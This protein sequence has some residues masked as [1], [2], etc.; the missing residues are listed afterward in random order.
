MSS[1][2]SILGIAEVVLNV[3]SLDLMR[4]FYQ[5]RLG[6]SVFSEASSSNDA[7][8]Q[9]PTICFLK[10]GSSSTPLGQNQHPVLLALIDFKRHQ[11]ASRFS[12]VKSQRST[13]NHL[14]FE[15]SLD[16]FDDQ[17]QRLKELGHQV[18]LSEFENMS[19]RALFFDDPEGNRIEFICHDPQLSL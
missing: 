14:A 8:D 16:E 5:S 4:D 17:A 15:I 2:P 6:L 9:S 12:E 13:L 7:T 10:I 19:A 3:H 1:P 18:Y 11:F